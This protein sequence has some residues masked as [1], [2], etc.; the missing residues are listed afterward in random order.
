[1]KHGDTVKGRVGLL[2]GEGK[3]IDTIYA[4]S[5]LS[6]TYSGGAGMMPCPCLFG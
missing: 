1:M 4:M 6:E 5:I 3:V 2:L